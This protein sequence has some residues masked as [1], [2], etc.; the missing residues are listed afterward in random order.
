M[1]SAFCQR[2]LCAKTLVE[3]VEACLKLCLTLVLPLPIANPIAN[4]YI[5]CE[6]ASVINVLIP[7]H[8]INGP[9]G[10]ERE[11]RVGLILER[12]S[13]MHGIIVSL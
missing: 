7:G 4:R 9:D 13:T 2:K 1:V 12:L 3:S 11:W 5:D 10:M 8:P 6:L